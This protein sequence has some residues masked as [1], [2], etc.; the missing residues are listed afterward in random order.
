M[1]GIADTITRLAA[2]AQ[3]ASG[4][5]DSVSTKLHPLED[6]GSNPGSLAAL[7]HIPADLP[8]GA[9]LVVV[10]HGCTQTAGGYDKASGWSKLADEQGFALL[11]PAQRQTNNANRCF[12]WFEVGDTRRDSGEALSI[13]QMIATVVSRHMI[14]RDRVFITGLS[15]GGAMASTMLATYPEVFAGGAIIAGLPH[16]VA[17]G[18]VQAFDRMRG[19][20]LPKSGRLQADL[21]EASD[22]EG[23]WPRISIW[24]GSEDGTVSPDNVEAIVEQWRCI[25]DLSKRPSGADQVDGAAH[26]FWRGKDGRVLIEAYIIPGMGHGTP[27]K[28]SGVGAYGSSA[29]FML[30]V[31]VSSTLLVAQFWQIIGPTKAREESF[32]RV[33]GDVVPHPAPTEPRRLHGERIEQTT[34]HAPEGIA[35]VIE[36]ALRTAGLMR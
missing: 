20:G 18:I 4:V 7:V 35:K 14:D 32:D 28:T 13:R 29:P 31:G 8:P 3:R 16:G 19:H 25:H 17:D 23:P 34:R 26:R 22:H 9:P 15:A 21:R 12:N 30:D 27:I 33:D 24:H 10:L 1:R 11:Y 2:A 5:D 36:D 6:F